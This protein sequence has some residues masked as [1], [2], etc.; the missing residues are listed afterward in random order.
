MTIQKKPWQHYHDSSIYIIDSDVAEVVT[1]WKA[2][3]FCREMGFRELI[4]E[5]DSMNVV[6]TLR[7]ET[8]CWSRFGQII[9]DT[10]IKIH[11]L[12]YD[13]RHT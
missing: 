9:E 13:V 11:S 12:H 5:G 7:H 10:K 6:T 3:T 8:S 2:M 4:F 1:A